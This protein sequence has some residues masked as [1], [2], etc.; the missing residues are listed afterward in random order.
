MTRGIT[1][2]DWAR[3]YVLGTGMAIL[4]LAFASGHLMMR[5]NRLETRIETLPECECQSSKGASHPC[6]R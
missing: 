3:L 4:I 2:K 6:G 1:G 5:L